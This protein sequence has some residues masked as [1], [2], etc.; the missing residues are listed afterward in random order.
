MEDIYNFCAETQLSPIP[1]TERTLLLFVTSMAASNISHSSIKVYLLAIRHMHIL[2]GLNEN[3]S[4]QFTTR[5]QLAIL[6][7]KGR[8]AVT[9]PSR[10]RL[11]ISMEMMQKIKHVLSQYPSSY[12]NVMLWA[13]CC[14][15]FFGF[16]Q[17][18]EF[19]VPTQR[20][21]RKQHICH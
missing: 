4:H 2:S 8:Q 6:G 12:D 11:P 21:M 19:T 1:A 16:L 15:T 18:S 9:S 14:L 17:V 20:I 10:T 5:L 7:I 13:A 3:L